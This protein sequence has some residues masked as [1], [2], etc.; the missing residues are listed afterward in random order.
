MSTLPRRAVAALT[1]LALAVLA[2]GCARIPTESEVRDGAADIEVGRDVDYIPVGPAAGAGPEQIVQGFLNAAVVGPMSTTSYAVAQE[3]L[4]PSAGAGWDRYARVLVLQE[5]PRLTVGEVDETTTTTIVQAEGLVVASVDERGVYSEQ[6]SPSTVEVAFAL[7]RG[8]DGQW[9][10]SQ[11][12]DGLL[13]SASL[14]TQAFHLTRLYF[15][16]PD[17]TALVPEVRWYPRQTWR[18]DATAAM[19][20]GP[21]EWLQQSTRTVIPD[22]T[23]LAIDAV[24]VDDDGTIEVPLTSAISEASVEQ[25]A[26]VV[27]QLEA[28]LVEG[29]GRAVAL[30]DGAAPLAVPS[31]TS[32]A[33]PRTSGDAVA[34][35]HG[36]LHRVVG[37]QLEVFEEPVPLEGLAPT[38]LAVE[39][40]DGRVVVRDGEQRLVRVTGADAPVTVLSGEG[41]LAPSIDRF[42]AVWSGGAGGIQVVLPSSRVVPVAAEWLAGR[43]V[44]AVRVSPEAA[45]VAVVSDG[46]GGRQ[47]HVAGVVRDAENAPTG[48]STPV[49]V[50][51]T[52]DDVSDVSWQDIAALAVVGRADGVPAVFLAGV[53]GLA[54]QGGLSRALAGVVDPRSVAAAVGSGAMLAVDA[55]G[56]LLSRQTAALWSTVEE[57]VQLVAYPG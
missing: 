11:L 6:A 9:R 4:T 21:P 50:G 31:T 25:R 43:T 16:T 36:Q 38:A 19:L 53:G 15:P 29:D 24:T 13:I 41:L 48:L 34:L 32:L 8:T 27:A 47:L 12:E 33:L 3:Y 17:L 37:R 30:F 28:T 44:V 14:F 10:I 26:L 56:T 20:E 39:P 35:A 18:T 1:A 52:I 49:P 51:A 54:S 5:N 57:D 2:A 7:S 42:G 55:D 22:G 23:T 40:G 46:P 45:R